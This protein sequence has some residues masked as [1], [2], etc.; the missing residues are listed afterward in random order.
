MRLD[1]LGALLEGEEGA[2]RGGALV[3]TKRP[4]I[5]VLD[6]DNGALGALLRKHYRVI[7]CPSAPDAIASWDDAIAAVII[8][9]KTKDS[10][11]PRACEQVREKNAHVPF[12]F[13]SA[14]PNAKDSFDIIQRHQPFAYITKG[15]DTK[16]LLYTVEQ[17]TRYYQVIADNKKAVAELQQIRARM[18][19]LNDN[20]K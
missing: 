10:D 20:T 12:I 11:D 18:A 19:A 6:D 5:L 15:T 14:H 8:D 13:Y 16:A 9:V 4:I 2:T 3:D 7:L 17:A 1:D